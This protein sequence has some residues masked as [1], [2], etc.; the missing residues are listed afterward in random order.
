MWGDARRA[1]GIAK[2]ATWVAK[3]CE[4]HVGNAPEISN[5]DWFRDT[6]RGMTLAP[7]APGMRVRRRDSGLTLVELMAVVV[8]LGILLAVAITTIRPSRGGAG[9]LSYARKVA[10]AVEDMRLRTISQ[11]RWQRLRVLGAR[12][13]VH[14]E[15]TVTGMATPTA[16]REVRDMTTPRGVSICG[17]EAELRLTPNGCP[18]DA[19]A[20]D[21]AIAPDGMSASPATF[22]I[23]DDVRADEK[24]RVTVYRA[25]GMPAL[26]KDH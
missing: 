5:F 18:E 24:Y 11:R 15:S 9:A 23:Q 22:Y 21:L 20:G 17:F 8:V 13:L 1:E 10:S 2:F 12:A 4:A 6:I 19:L 16:W 25:T 26:Y 3:V 7:E 14:E